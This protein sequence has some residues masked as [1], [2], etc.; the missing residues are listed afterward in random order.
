M[1]VGELRQKP[2]IFGVGPCAGLG[3]VDMDLVLPWEIRFGRFV[4]EH[5]YII[6]EL[7]YGVSLAHETVYLEPSVRVGYNF[8]HKKN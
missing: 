7:T 6:F 3:F 1:E 4:S 8:G 5:W 2:F